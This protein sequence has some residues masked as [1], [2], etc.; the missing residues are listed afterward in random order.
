[1]I[2]FTFLIP[3]INKVESNLM[4]KQQYQS[5]NLAQKCWGT[6]PQECRKDLKKKNNLKS[7]PGKRK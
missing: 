3:L 7:L 2:I 4:V 1:M 6:E 5:Q